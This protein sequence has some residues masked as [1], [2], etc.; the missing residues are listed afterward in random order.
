[1]PA[2]LCSLF[3]TIFYLLRHVIYVLTLADIVLCPP[4]S[5]AH[6]WQPAPDARLFHLHVTLH[7]LVHLTARYPP[8]HR[9]SPQTA[10][11]PTMSWCC[12]RAYQAGHPPLTSPHRAPSRTTRASTPSVS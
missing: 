10:S 3:I 11:V 12:G 2:C 5:P 1:M 4:A 8:H 9:L 6:H 7:E